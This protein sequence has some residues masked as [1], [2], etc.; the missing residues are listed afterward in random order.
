MKIGAVALFLVGSVVLIDAARTP[1]HDG[2]ILSP[3]GKYI[4]GK[5]ELFQ[6]DKKKSQNVISFI[7]L[8]I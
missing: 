7:Y 1:S 6:L 2:G 4:P 3:C 8:S 5:F